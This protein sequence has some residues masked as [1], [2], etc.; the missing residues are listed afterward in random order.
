VVERDHDH[1]QACR[2]SIDSS[3][4]LDDVSDLLVPIA[5]VANRA[6]GWLASLRLTSALG[7]SGT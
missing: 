4:R 5:D 6:L 3:P 1:D 2:T 7:A